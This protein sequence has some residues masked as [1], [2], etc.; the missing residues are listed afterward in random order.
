MANQLTMHDSANIQRRSINR[1]LQRG[2]RAAVSQTSLL[3]K[4]HPKICV[5]N[6]PWF[7]K[8]HPSGNRTPLFR[9]IPG[10]VFPV[11]PHGKPCPGI[12]VQNGPHF[13]GAPKQ[14]PATQPKW[15]AFLRRVC[16]KTKLRWNS[17]CLGLNQQNRNY[18]TA[19]AKPALATNVTCA[20]LVGTHKGTL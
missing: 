1:L 18:S 5:Q 11:E 14:P 19:T 2:F 6:G 17:S 20:G 9:R 3:R 7:P 12:C 15:S 4:L 10:R 8:R 13:P 16:I